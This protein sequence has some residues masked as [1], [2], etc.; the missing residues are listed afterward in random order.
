MSQYYFHYDLEKSKV[1]VCM[2]PSYP[3]SFLFRD[4]HR[5]NSIA[6]LQFTTKLNPLISTVVEVN[7]I[8]CNESFSSLVLLLMISVVFC[9]MQ[10]VTRQT[11]SLLLYTHT[12]VCMCVYVYTQYLKRLLDICVY[13]HTAENI[14][15]LAVSGPHFQCAIGVLSVFSCTYVCHFG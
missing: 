13:E 9:L 3:G 4:I 15:Y 10:Q 14:I 1:C 2:V 12:R 11:V 7:E 5:L 8:N 6:F